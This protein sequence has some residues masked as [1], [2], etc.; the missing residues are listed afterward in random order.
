MHLSSH[1]NWRSTFGGLKKVRGTTKDPEVVNHK[2][3]W[4]SEHRNVCRTV[5]SLCR[6][7]PF[8]N[9]FSALID[10][11]TTS[12]Y[13]ISHELSLPGPFTGFIPVDNGMK[14]IIKQIERKGNDFL[15]DFIRS[16]FTL[17]LWLHRDITGSST[18][19]WL[20][21]NKERKAPEHLLSL[22][23]SK[24]VIE[25]IG[26]ISRGTDLTHINGSKILRWNMR[27]HNGVIHLID[28]PMM[29]L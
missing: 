8:T 13:A 1:R 12:G 25:N 17:D 11:E 20:L 9:I 7:H 24:L 27:C 29:G 19:P 15:V 6:T 18:Q 2:V 26:E 4:F 28:R 5:L 21:Y 22:T 23:N 10:P 16:H 14:Q 3:Y